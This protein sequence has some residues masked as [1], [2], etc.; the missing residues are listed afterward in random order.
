MRTSDLPAG[1]L[2][3]VAR[4][5]ELALRADNKSANTIHFYIQAVRLL[6]EWAHRQ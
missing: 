6:G 1:R 5:W 4:S 2:E 3:S